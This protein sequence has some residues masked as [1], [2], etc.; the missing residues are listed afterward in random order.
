LF[1]ADISFIFFFFCT[2]FI[3]NYK[4]IKVIKRVR[5]DLIP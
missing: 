2:I 1:I 4:Y 3:L 5:V